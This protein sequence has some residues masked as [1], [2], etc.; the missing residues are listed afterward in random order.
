MISVHLDAFSHDQRRLQAEEIID[1][2]NRQAEP[3]IFVCGDFNFDYDFLA[4]QG[5][6]HSDV[7]LYRYLTR[8]F[9]DLGRGA[10]GSTTVLARRVD[11]I[12]ART[13]GVVRRDVRILSGQRVHLMDHEPV[14]GRFEIRR[15]G[16]R[17][18]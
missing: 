11:Y 1:W 4:R 13:S 8:S 7:S 16:S 17:D 10:G 18:R 9:E 6:E 14:L 15:P 3:E 12:L 2:A 5:A